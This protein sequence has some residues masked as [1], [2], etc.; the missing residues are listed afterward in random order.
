M[1]RFLHLIAT[2][3]TVTGLG[4][5][6]VLA[7][8]VVDVSKKA[9]SEWISYRD[10]YKLMVSFEK[11]GKSKHLIQNRFQIVIKDKSIN[12]ENLRLT[13]NAKSSVM[14]LGLDPL[15]QTQLPLLKAAYDENA[16]LSLSPKLSQFTYRSRVSIQLRTDGNYEVADLRT[17]CEQ[18]LAYMQQVDSSNVSG[19]KC[20]G[21]KFGFDKRDSNASIEVRTPNQVAFNLPITDNGL[22]WNDSNNALRVSQF[23]FNGGTDRGH[24]LTRTTPI[25][26]VA[27]IE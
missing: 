26:I 11:Y 17:A 25:I 4:A 9:D 24:L 19:K 23:S 13:L 3:F 14:N 21:V 20:V 1:K 2:V 5:S 22:I 15:G 6:Q 27:V 10:A 12:L 7:Q 18:T 8:S 16:E